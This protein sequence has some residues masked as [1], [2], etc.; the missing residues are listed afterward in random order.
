V[1]AL[2]DPATG[3]LLGFEVLCGDDAQRFL[4]LAVVEL[5][6]DEIGVGSALALIDER[7]LGYYRSRARS[8]N[9]LGFADPWVDEQ[10]VVHEALSAA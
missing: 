3:R 8:I 10:G 6:A 7:D 4:P 9:D 1:D 5:R 2:V